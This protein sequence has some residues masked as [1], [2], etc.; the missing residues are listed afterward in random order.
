MTWEIFKGTENEWQKKF[1][2]YDGHYRQSYQW[3]NY[4]SRMGWKVIRLSKKSDDKNLNLVQITYKKFK[5]FCA[6]YIPGEI[7]GNSINLDEEFRKK[8]LEHT[9]SKILYIRIDS[10]KKN[11]INEQQNLK[12]NL[13]SRPFAQKQVPKVSICELAKDFEDIIKFSSDGWKKNYKKSIKNFNNKEFNIKIT[14]KPSPEELVFISNIFTKNKKIY[15]PH[16]EKEFQHM[17]NTLDK[18]IYFCIAYNKVNEPI[19]YRGLIYFNDNAW[20]LAAATTDKGRSLL[21]SFYIT[22]ELIKKCKSIGIKTYNF[23]EMDIINKKG[24]YHFKQGIAKNEINISG[25]WE[26]SNFYIIKVLAN[27][28]ISIVL[29]N[30]V[31]KFIP[32][33]NNLKF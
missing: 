3:G 30:K 28:F 9:K 33:I 24:V 5:F 14:N 13:W 26:H 12:L 17:I 2:E 7:L 22:A 29:S 19:A 27:F 20:D 18:N 16:S 25:E 6:A 11:I 32:F 8:I 23:G 1:F 15:K 4:K 10:T 21:P 31:R